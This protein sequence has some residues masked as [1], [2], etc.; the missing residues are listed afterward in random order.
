MK[1][2][3]ITDIH[4]N[5]TAL[6]AVMKELNRAECEKI[7]CCGDIIGIGPYPE[8]TVQYMMRIPDLIAVRGNHETYLLEGMPDK[9]PNGEN[10][11]FG[12]IE[13]HKWEHQQL[14]SESIAFLSG[15]PYQINTIF[16]GLSVSVLHSC[17]DRAGHFSG[18]VRDPSES[19]L[20][21]MFADIESQIVLYGHDHSRKI[22]IGDKCY[23]NVGSLGCPSQERNIARAGIASIE[24][25]RIS[26]DAIDVVY[27]V[28]EIICQIDKL[29]YPDAENIKKYFF[30]L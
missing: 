27:D 19:D 30:G 11:S 26:V 22:C 1:F 14:S 9:Y 23:I 29:K 21:N 16:D 8:E 10:M 6:R 3:I 5:V 24:D 20:R 18:S 13:H 15:L 28:N 4:N 12:E 7:V 17:M 25:G 2:G